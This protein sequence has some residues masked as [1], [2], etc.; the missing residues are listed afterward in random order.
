M[1]VYFCFGDLRS[2]FEALNPKLPRSLPS[3]PP[4]WLVISEHGS[5]RATSACRVSRTD[6]GALSLNSLVLR[7]VRNSRGQA[8]N[9]EIAEPK[10]A[11]RPA[12]FKLTGIRF[13]IRD[14]REASVLLEGLHL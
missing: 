12:A 2:Q 9:A 6:I 4:P 11:S 10:E 7:P 13:K 3:L 1:C 14:L 8:D 5:G